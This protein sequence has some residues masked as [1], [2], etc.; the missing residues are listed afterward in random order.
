MSSS[1]QYQEATRRKRKI[2][3]SMSS[4]SNSVARSSDS[5]IDEPVL[6]SISLLQSDSVIIPSS[7]CFLK[8]APSGQKKTKKPASWDVSVIPGIPLFYPLE[9]TRVSIPSR[10]SSPTEIAKRIVKCLEDLSIA[11]TYNKDQALAVAETMDGVQLHICLFQTREKDTLV[12]VQRKSGS[13]LSFHRHARII[14]KCA[15]SGDRNENTNNK[16]IMPIRRPV[17]APPPSKSPRKM[18][19][20]LELACS[21]LKKDRLDANQLGMESLVFLTDATL[22]DLNSIALPVSRILLQGGPDRYNNDLHHILLNYIQGKNSENDDMDEARDDLATS[23]DLEDRHSAIM[24]YNALIVLANSLE[25]IRRASSSELNT[26]LHDQ[27]LKDLLAVL[28]QEVSMA[29]VQP[30]NAYQATRCLSAL[31]ESSPTTRGMVKEMGATDILSNSH[32]GHALLR[33]ESHSILVAL[34]IDK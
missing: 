21:M 12:E 16:R 7:D 32:V 27:G 25:T 14:L 6:R 22:C 20:A 34:D 15:V 4:T 3:N 33:Q 23:N 19:S 28:V 17:L 30:H 8:Q 13:S 9:Q 24:H 10:E 5:S 11:A 29:E 1:Q 2:S 26:I 18:E 31:L